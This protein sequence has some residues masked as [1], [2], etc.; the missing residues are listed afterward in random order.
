MRQRCNRQERRLQATRLGVFGARAWEERDGSVVW[1]TGALG[2]SPIKETRVKR[3]AGCN[4]SHTQL[5]T[6]DAAC[7]AREV[8]RV[9]AQHIPGTAHHALSTDCIACVCDP[10]PGRC[11]CWMLESCRCRGAAAGARAALL[12]VCTFELVAEQRNRHMCKVSDEESQHRHQQQVQHAIAAARRLDW[13]HTHTW[14]ERSRGEGSQ[15]SDQRRN[16]A[17]T[18]AQHVPHLTVSTH[19]WPATQHG[20]RC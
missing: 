18:A 12:P 16:T 20:Q 8:R 1:C 14:G 3:K 19:L 13:L 5:L 6:R 11:C 17:G 2:Y 7:K 9:G 4:C 10:H 15:T